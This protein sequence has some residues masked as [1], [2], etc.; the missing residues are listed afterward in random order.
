[1]PGKRR[2]GGK[3]GTGISESRNPTTDSTH[4]KLVLGITNT[5][6]LRPCDYV[7]ACKLLP[8]KA[9]DLIAHRLTLG[10][11]LLQGSVPL[12]CH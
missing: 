12:P 7:W 2:V 1:M 8:G 10:T 9:V 5:L 6:I 11:M 3:D 4:V